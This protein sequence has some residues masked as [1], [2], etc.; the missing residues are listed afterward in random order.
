MVP[1]KAAFGITVVPRSGADV[2][3]VGK[4]DLLGR[5]DEIARLYEGRALTFS[6]AHEFRGLLAEWMKAEKETLAALDARLEAMAIAIARKKRSSEAAL[7][8]I[9]TFFKDV[10]NP[11]RALESLTQCLYVARPFARARR[12]AGGGA[13]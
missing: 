12:E 10:E 11:R 4:W 1:G 3:V 7:E 6:L 8:L 2:R 5:I 9:R 13:S